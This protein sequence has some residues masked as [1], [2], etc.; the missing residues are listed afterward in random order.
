LKQQAQVDESSHFL[1]I[2]F[3][4]KYAAIVCVGK[5]TQTNR[6]KTKTGSCL[7]I[8]KQMFP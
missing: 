5:A 7:L 2:P 4:E 6:L 8:G 1:C 3:I